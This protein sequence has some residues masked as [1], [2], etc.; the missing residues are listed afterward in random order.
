MIIEKINNSFGIRINDVDIIQF[1]EREL[2]ELKHLLKQHGLIYLPRQSLSDEQIVRL[3]K[4][5]GNGELGQSGAKIN[6]TS[7]FENINNM[8]NL[9]DNDSAPL[10][11]AGN[12][13]DFW[14]SD[15]A[16]RDYPAT[17]ALLYC[18]VPSE[19]GGKTSF[20]STKLNKLTLTESEVSTLRT[21][22]SVF[23]PASF[24]DNAPTKEVF[25]DTI[26][27][28]QNGDE[29]SLYISENT[30]RLENKYGDDFSGLL[31]P[32][33]DKI[34][35][36]GDKYSHDWRIGDLLLFDNLQLLH[37]R[38]KFVGTRWLKAVKIHADG[39][40]FK[41]IKSSI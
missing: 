4:S 11:Y 10:G 40:V 23:Q 13:T 5:L 1:S 7:K 33:L 30:L 31:A 15:Q 3:C 27:T 37:R 22:K 6:L 21:L 39:E 14:H 35:N 17:N 18:V 34:I 25:H 32:L 20:V 41:Q 8:T 24:H 29:E 19:Q 2:K 36:Q 16:F 26:V 38:E 9:R 28:N 12:H